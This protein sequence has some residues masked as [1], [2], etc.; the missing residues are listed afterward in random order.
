MNKFHNNLGILSGLTVMIMAV[1][2]FGIL[3]TQSSADDIDEQAIIT[4]PAEDNEDDSVAGDKTELVDEPVEEE[5][6]PVEEDVPDSINGLLIGFDRTG[7]LTDVIMVGRV[8]PKN[9]TVK[10]ISIPRDL[11]VYFTDDEFKHIKENNPKNRVL[12][13]KMNEIYSLIGW[14]E[15][16][17]QDVKAVVEVITGLEMDYMM[18]IDI[19]GFGDMVDV[20][21]GV[22]F[23]VPQDMYYVDPYQ[24]LYIDLKEGLQVLDGD[25][26]EQLVRFRKGSHGT[27][28]YERGDLQRIE[29]QQQFVAAFV[30][31]VSG[32]RDFD[33]ISQ[34]IQKGYK[35]VDTDFG[36]VVM[37]EYAEFFFE[38]ELEHILSGENMMTIPSYGEKVDG[39]WYQ[40]FEL[41]EARAAVEELLEESEAEE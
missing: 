27:Q 32:L 30:D 35:L 9:N 31:Q 19:S 6:A 36:L 14:N 38:L 5:T 8:D 20:V 25:K 40:F 39:R 12:H 1:S 34:L 41:E 17:L 37:L 24:D 33:Q 22:E 7:G 26:A 21:G 10:I 16:A 11:E 23:D 18:T 29:V 15:R 2:L 3:G 13:C 4:I 28:G